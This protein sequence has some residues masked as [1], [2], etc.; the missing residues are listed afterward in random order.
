MEENRL[1]IRICLSLLKKLRHS[2]KHAEAAKRSLQFELNDFAKKE[3]ELIKE[4]EKAN[5]IIEKTLTISIDRL[6]KPFD[7]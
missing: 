3:L 5:N 7:I 1:L 4:Q 2:K 6:H